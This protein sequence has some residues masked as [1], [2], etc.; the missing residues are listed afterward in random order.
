MVKLLSDLAKLRL[1][2]ELRGAVDGRAAELG[3]GPARIDELRAHL[4]KPGNRGHPAADCTQPRPQQ[5]RYA[6]SRQALH[7]APVNGIQVLGRTTRGRQVSAGLRVHHLA[8]LAQLR[9]HL[10]QVFIQFGQGL[11]ERRQNL[12]TQGI[13]TQAHIGITG[14]F[15]PLQAGLL[16][17]IAQ[18][19]AGQIDQRAQ[20]QHALTHITRR[21]ATQTIQPAAT[22]QRQQQRLELIIRMVR[23]QQSLRLRITTCGIQQSVA[24]LARPAFNVRTPRHGP[25]YTQA[26]KAHRKPGGLIG[27]LC[28]PAA[29]RRLQ[30]MMHMQRDDRAFAHLSERCMQENGRVEA[31]AE[32]NG[33]RLRGAGR[34]PAERSPQRII[35]RV[36]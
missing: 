8:G 26:V 18:Q 36:P 11:G 15:D 34:Q 33:Q 1:A 22:G 9:Q 17:L 31:T 25:W 23:G 7:G 10:G 21:H 27:A 29:R 19:G 3:L 4:R 14:I 24:L 16:R 20:Q 30:P 2:P 6:R 5:H 28:G 12:M 13:A 35:N 32:R